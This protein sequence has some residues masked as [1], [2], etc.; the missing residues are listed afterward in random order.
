MFTSTCPKC[1]GQGAF[2]RHACKTC[3]GHGVVE[4]PR[5]VTVGF[6]AGIDAGQRLRVP[7]QGL[8]GPGGSQSGDLYVEID[9]EEDSRF[10]RDGADL[11]TRVHVN[12]AQA[13]LG[14]DIEVPALEQ[15]EPDKRVAVTLPAGTQPGAVLT[16]RGHGVPRLDGRGRGNLVVAVQVDV[17]KALSAR[18]RDL[19]A[20]LE[21]ELAGEA[22]DAE[23]S[24]RRSANASK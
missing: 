1:Q 5:K 3:E 12:F 6:P 14:A 7:G 19:L 8:P 2:I 11:V 9:V 4:R 23:T 20:E 15:G 10:E 18:A 13:A 24:R 17:P 16:L 22:D 21:V